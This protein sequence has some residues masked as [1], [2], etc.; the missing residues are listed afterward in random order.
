MTKKPKV[1]SLK[2]ISGVEEETFEIEDESIRLESVGRPAWW[3]NGSWFKPRTL[4]ERKLAT[5]QYRS[6]TRD[7][8]ILS[9]RASKIRQYISILSEWFP[10]SL[11]D[12]IGK[13]ILMET[14]IR[15]KEEDL[16]IH[17]LGALE[18]AL[19]KRSCTIRWHVL[20][21]IAQTIGQSI[22]KKDIYKWT[23]YTRQRKKEATPD[24][25]RIIQRIT[26]EEILKESMPPKEKRLICCQVAEACKVLRTKGFVCKDPEIAAWSLK[27][28]FLEKKGSNM[29]V[30]KELRA[31]TA[32]MTF[33]IRN[34]L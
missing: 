28:I 11:L 10:I 7:E 13:E 17:F 16:F 26:V 2:S 9:E 27:R 29:S 18:A 15:Q 31:A 4:Q 20:H 3:F 1:G 23:F 30:P 33:R 34:F 14:N 24:T 5:L 22:E 21:E 32:R 12:D 8:A 25:L 6:I 19:R